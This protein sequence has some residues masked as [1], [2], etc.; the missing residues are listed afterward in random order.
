[1]FSARNTTQLGR[2]ILPD[3]WYILQSQQ[4]DSGAREKRTF[5]QLLPWVKSDLEN[6]TTVYNVLY[7][8]FKL[9]A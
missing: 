6:K 7:I 8:K 5:I 4:I 3:F 9:K 1:M 2:G